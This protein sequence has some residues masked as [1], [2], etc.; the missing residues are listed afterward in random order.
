MV[1]DVAVY[2]TIS[3]VKDTF[4]LVKLRTN[5]KYR[6]EENKDDNYKNMWFPQNYWVFGLRPASG[7]L[8]TRKHNVSETGSVSILRWGG[9]RHLLYWVPKKEL[10]SIN[11][12]VRWE[13]PT[14][15]CP[16]ERANLNQWTSEGGDTYS[17]GSHRKS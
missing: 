7:I 10:T 6:V 2:S 14:L 11:G 15:L 1:H 17:V 9:R 5:V 4:C 13:I 16:L 3:F 8:E 12:P